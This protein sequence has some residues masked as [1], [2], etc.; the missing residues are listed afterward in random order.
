MLAAA[1]IGFKCGEVDVREQV[2]AQYL[3]IGIDYQ[4][5]VVVCGIDEWFNL[6][7]IPKYVQTLQS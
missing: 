4:E 3:N 1:N 5:N 7:P 6:A 2:L